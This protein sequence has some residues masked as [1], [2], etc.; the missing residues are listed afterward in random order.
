MTLALMKTTAPQE[1]Q[2][3][4]LLQRIRSLVT[5]VSC[6]AGVHGQIAA[7][8]PLDRG[9]QFQSVRDC[10]SACVSLTIPSIPTAD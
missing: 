9:A 3:T 10:Y 8:E 5:R 6:E 7:K 2:E 1:D 4:P